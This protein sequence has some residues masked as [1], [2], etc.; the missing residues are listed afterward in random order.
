MPIFTLEVNTTPN[1]MKTKDDK[2]KMECLDVA[3]VFSEKKYDSIYK[4]F[5]LCERKS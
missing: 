4:E 3:Q 1:R 5:V 2:L